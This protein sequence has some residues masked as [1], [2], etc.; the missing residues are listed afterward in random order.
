MLLILLAKSQERSQSYCNQYWNSNILLFEENN[1][2][3]STT[4]EER[5]QNVINNPHIVDWFFTQRVESFIKYW[6]YDAL[7]AKWHWC[8]F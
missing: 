8:R 2:N 3:I 5:R 7:Y 6:L 4:S 1:S